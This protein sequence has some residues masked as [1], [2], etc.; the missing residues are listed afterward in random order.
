MI[1]R[2]PG[3]GPWS[4]D[5]GD[6]YKFTTAGPPPKTAP[7]NVKIRA[8]GRS[9]RVSWDPVPAGEPGNKVHSYWVRKC[10]YN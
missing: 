7:S 9:V 6:S 10:N 8:H 5:I 1:L 3:M 2:F 4:S